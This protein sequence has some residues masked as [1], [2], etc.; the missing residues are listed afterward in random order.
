MTAILSSP[1]SLFR[2]PLLPYVIR[3]WL[4]SHC[5]IYLSPILMSPPPHYTLGT[6]TPPPASYLLNAVFR[7]Q[8]STRQYLRVCARIAAKSTVS[9]I[10]RRFEPVCEACRM[11]PAET[12]HAQKRNNYAAW[13]YKHQRWPKAGVGK[14]K[15]VRPSC[16]E[17]KTKVKGHGKITGDNGM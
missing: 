13:V 17:R 15:D 12:C 16:V 11:R 6:V 2:T 9:R 1:V 8:L 4:S 5:F 10:M 14:W 7:K 3:S